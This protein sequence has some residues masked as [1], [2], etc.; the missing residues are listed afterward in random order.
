M[1]PLS[2]A[3]SRRAPRQPRVLTDDTLGG[4][5]RAHERAPAFGG[6]DGQAYSVATFVDDTPDA[7]GQFGAALLFVRWSEAGDR[8]VGHLETEY[9][10]FGRTA[11]DALEPL[12]RLTLRDV[13]AYLDGCIERAGRGTRDGGG[14]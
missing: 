8:P 12:L 11:A 6:A 4:Y 9:L 7:H 1:V 13:K 14:V 2:H 5:Q 3:P 10:A